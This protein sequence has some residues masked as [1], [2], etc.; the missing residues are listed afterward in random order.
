MDNSSV[1]L[2]RVSTKEQAEGYSLESQRKGNK[3]YTQKKQLDLKKSFTIHES[4]SKTEQRKIFR[5]M[6]EYVE[7][8]SIKHIVCEKV[9]RFSRSI[10]EAKL[11]YDWL[12]ADEKRNLHF[13]KENLIVNK[14]SKSHEKLNL[15]MKVVLAQFYADNL[16]E[17]VKKGQEGKLENGWYPGPAKFGYKTIKF[18][19]KHVPIPDEAFAPLLK[20]GLELFTTGNYSV[21]KLANTMFEEGLR[22][23]KGFKVSPARWHDHL[24]DPF[25]YGPF[26]WNNELH[27]EHKHEPLIT[28]EVY[29]KNQSLL[30]RKNAPKYTTHNHLFK[31][32]T[33]C[34]E[35]GNSIT[36][37]VQKGILYGYCNRY[38]PCGQI[39]SIKVEDIEP[40][41]LVALEALQV[42]NQRLMEWLRKA[43]KEGHKEE[44]DY[45]N[46]A[47]S[48][49][50]VK[51]TQV[52]RRIDNLVD[53]RVDELI[54]KEGFDRKLSQYKIEKE[55]LTQAIQKHSRLQVKQAEYSVSFYELAQKAKEIYQEVKL[56]EKRRILRHM[57][58]TLQ[59]R[60]N[61]KELVAT[62]TKPFQMLVELAELTNSSNVAVAE[63]KTDRIFEPSKKTDTTLQTATFLAAYPILR[64]GQDSNLRGLT[65]TRFPSVLLK[66]LGHPTS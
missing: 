22:S 45:H 25:Y 43:I 39:A 19:G 5:K 40:Q 56:E 52:Q 13:I 33:T 46:A 27:F 55:R 23:K 50:E 35:C 49:L 60:P 64:W 12:S 53:M 15:N 26:Y 24:I 63:V 8:H 9:D 31:G 20:K 28:E 14:N 36:W 62:F 7:K 16:S 34:L 51:L 57:F 44:I 2:E 21:Q 42:K 17:E 38:K 61:T 47:L 4:A 1:G 54:D 29:N 41:L 11:I 3:S 10:V 37:E 58:S 32:I 66:P 18:E 30:R 6:M 59:V 65:T 48:E